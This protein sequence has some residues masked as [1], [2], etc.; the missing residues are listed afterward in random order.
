MGNVPVLILVEIFRLNQQHSF[1]GW[2]IQL[3]IIINIKYSDTHHQ[4][5]EKGH[6][7]RL[8]N[9]SLNYGNSKSSKLSNSND[10]FM[11]CRYWYT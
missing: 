3:I 10:F 6:T 1:S 8:A 5:K 7:A 9:F 4:T 11:L 2:E